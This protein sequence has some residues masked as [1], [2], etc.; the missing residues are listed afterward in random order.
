MKEKL[1]SIFTLTALVITLISTEVSHA[2]GGKKNESRWQEEIKECA[3]KIISSYGCDDIKLTRMTVIGRKI[4]AAYKMEAWGSNYFVKVTLLHKS[5]SYVQA[6]ND[7]HLIEENSTIEEQLN[8][9]Y[10]APNRD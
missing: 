6:F 9:N 3:C 1:G 8:G 2:E 4:H 10:S 7:F 5:L